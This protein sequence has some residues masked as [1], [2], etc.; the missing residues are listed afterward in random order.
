MEMFSGKKIRLQTKI[1]ILVCTVVLV[2]VS[3]TAYLIGSKAVG[4]SRD[5]QANKVMDIARTISHSKLIKDGL[6]GNGPVEAIQSFTKEVQEDTNVQYIV[7]LN[8]EH[9]RQSHPVT[10]RIGENFVGGD[11]DRAFKGESYI[12]SAKGTLGESLRAFVPIYDDDEFVGVVSVG[13]LSENI[14]ATVI[15]SLRTSY[16]GIGVGLLIGIVGAFL[17]ARQVKRTLYGLEPDEIAKLLREREAMLESVKEGIIA[18]ND[19]AEIIVANQAASQLFRQA[20]LI[21]NPIGKQVNAYLPTSQLQEVLQTG[22]PAFDQEQKLNG[23]DIVVNRV[24]VILNGEIVGALATFRDKTELASLVEQLSGAKAFAETLRVQTHEF[25]NK[26]HVMTAMVHTK[27]YD[28]LKEY[29][30]Y[31]SDAYQK[32]VGAVSRLIKDPVISGYLVNKLSKSRE[33]GIHIELTGANPLPRLKKIENMD[34]I[35]TILGNLFDNASEAVRDQEYAHIDITINYRDKHLLFNIKDNGP[36][37]SGNN[38]EE[39]SMIGL[40]TKG[41]N[42]G[43]GLYLI[44][45]SLNELGGTIE[46]SQDKG[47]GTQFQVKIPYEGE[48]N[49]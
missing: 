9:I 32:E 24:P 45:K 7:V 14:Q 41:E 28:E 43:Y 33:S 17:L 20:G 31:L 18:V 21:E 42:R 12:S 22:E 25:M 19:K 38:F 10:D 13:I 30:T 37:F 6:S 46:V 39:T 36:G 11:E 40:S 2:S 44:N 35:I 15:Q 5:F 49:D 23:I 4:N 34:R 1:M 16:I 3:V 26:L 27:S 47:A 29:T 8:K 48:T